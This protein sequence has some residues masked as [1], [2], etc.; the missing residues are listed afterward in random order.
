VIGPDGRPDP[1]KLDFIGRRG[2]DAS[3]RT[4]ETFELIRP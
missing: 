3:A 4:R 2:G 1:A